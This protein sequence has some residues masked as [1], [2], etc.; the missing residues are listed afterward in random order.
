MLAPPF[1]A[2]TGSRTRVE[3]STGLHDRPLHYPDSKQGPASQIR[4]GD[5]AVAARCAFWRETYYSRALY[6]AEL[7]RVQR[8]KA[9]LV[10]SP[11]D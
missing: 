7:R 4:T 8:C 11:F 2:R 10:F 6:Q 9:I 5:I 3:A 1:S